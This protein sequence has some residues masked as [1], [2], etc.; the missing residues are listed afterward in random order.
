[1][2]LW[3]FSCDSAANTGAGSS[4]SWARAITQSQIAGVAKPAVARMSGSGITD[5][6][7]GALRQPSSETARRSWLQD[8]SFAAG[9][10]EGSARS[11]SCAW[12]P[13]CPPAAAR[14]R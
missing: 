14:S 11:A 6:N 1:M 4:R 5:S 10:P 7:A 12:A 2:S 3:T 13:A 8:R 9:F